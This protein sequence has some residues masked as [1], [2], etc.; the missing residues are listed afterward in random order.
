MQIA[1][2]T[3]SVEEA[4]SILQH[5]NVNRNISK[6]RVKCY[7][8]DLK[9][10]NWQL[11]GDP[12]VID[13]NG[14]LKN[15]QHRLSAIV[16]A[17]TP[18]TTV[19]LR[20]Q[21]VGVSVYDRGRNRSVSDCLV[22]E[23]MDK[24][25]ANSLNVG[26]I[27]LHY[28]MQTNRGSVSD[29]DIK[30]MLEKYRETLVFLGNIKIKKGTLK[31]KNATVLLACLYAIESGVNKEK[32]ADFIKVLATGF[33]ESKSQKAAIVLRND[34]LTKNVVLHTGGNVTRVRAVKIVEKAINDFSN[35]YERRTS[36]R[37]STAP[38][39]SNNARFKEV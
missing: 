11:S 38:I 6:D 22:L 20:D 34:I 17:N 21:P 28:F 31:A 2:E 37:N 10:G 32:V 16:S 27:K 36:Y 15:G 4:K 7:A 14:N 33:Y 35:G 29:F 23:G 1:V 5:N 30:R 25:L 12:I 13:E 8:K 26:V 9:E 39:Y 18:M 3:I 24:T 19:V